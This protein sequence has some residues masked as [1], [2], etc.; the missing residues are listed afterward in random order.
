MV[1]LSIG[2]APD[3]SWARGT[4]VHVDQRGRILAD[5]DTQVTSNPRVFLA[6]EALRGP[7]SAIQAIADGHRAAD[8]V[9]RFLETG[10]ATK[11]AADEATPLAA[12]PEETVARLRKIAS[13]APEA[14]P[15]APDEPLIDEESAW[16][17][18]GRCLGCMAGAVIDETRCASCLTCY[19]VC[20]L[21][22][23]E[24]G[25]AM[26]ADPVRCQACGVCASVC[27]AG[28]IMLPLMESVA[29]ME[30]LSPQAPAT[31]MPAT[32]AMACRHDG[33]R[34]VEGERTLYVPC[35]ARLKSVQVL[36]LFRRGCKTVRLYPCASDACKYG[37]AW[38]NIESVVGHVREVLREARPE[39]QLELC[40]PEAVA[41]PAP[42][43]R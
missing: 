18:G 8:I 15:F 13:L 10:E 4:P 31:G 20:P 33:H 36:R 2:Q 7:G 32:V 42:Q 21:D 38:K 27:P 40:V 25:E 24:I 3:R 41:A 22:A 43:E 26:A 6:G 37:A 11:P 34:A 16:R 19:R 1:I 9:A 12:Y 39:A 35:L 14:Q 5:R 17:E 28:A 30:P 29:G 23:V